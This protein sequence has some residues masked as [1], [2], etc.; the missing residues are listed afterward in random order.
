MARFVKLDHK[1]LLYINPDHVVC[2]GVPQED[3]VP[4]LGRTLLT[5]S[6]GQMVVDMAPQDVLKVINEPT[7]VVH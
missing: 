2:V 3:G 5:M 7:V 1:S 6:I 4:M